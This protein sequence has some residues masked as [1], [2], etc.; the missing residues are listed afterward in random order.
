MKFPKILAAIVVVSSLATGF[1]LAEEAKKDAAPAGK[2]AACCEKADGK[3][4]HSCCVAAA[5]DGKNCEKCGGT[6]TAA[7]AKK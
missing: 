2:K 5:K 6:N 4:E 7:P 1:L 3:C